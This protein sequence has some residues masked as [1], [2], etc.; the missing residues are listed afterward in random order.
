MA[1]LEGVDIDTLALCLNAMEDSLA[2]GQ[3]ASLTIYS[4]LPPTAEELAS[5]YLTALDVGFH[6]SM[7]RAVVGTGISSTTIVLRKG[8][9]Q[10]QMLLALLP[11]VLTVGLVAFS[12][13]RIQSISRALIPIFLIG[14]GIVIAA[15]ALARRPAEKYIEAGGRLRAL[16]A[17][18]GIP[19]KA[20]AA[21]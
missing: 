14:G 19:P 21:R 8:S 7:P 2:V 11:T 3:K 16:P 10:W 5:L 6:L 17:T 9:P 4:D 12:I 15:L 18:I 20:P 13:T 1:E